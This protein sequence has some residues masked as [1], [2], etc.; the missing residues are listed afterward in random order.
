V[1]SCI[2]I[3][4]LCIALSGECIV[5]EKIASRKPRTVGCDERGAAMRSKTPFSGMRK[6]GVAISCFCTETFRVFRRCAKRSVARLVTCIRR[7]GK[8][9]VK[10]FV[11]CCDAVARVPTRADRTRRIYQI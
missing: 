8:S 1:L 11:P 2:R 3:E 4:S 7:S 6:R 10:I 5:G 9:R